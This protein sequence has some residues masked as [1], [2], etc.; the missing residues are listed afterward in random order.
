MVLNKTSVLLADDHQIVLDGLQ[1][2]LEPEFSIV[3]AVGDGRALIQAAQR[4]KPDVIVVDISMPLLNGID[5]TRKIRQRDPDARIIVLTM[6]PDLP[7]ATEAFE[8][9]AMGYVIKTSAGDELV[10]AIEAVMLGHNYVT[11]S[12]AKDL[13]DAVIHGRAESGDTGTPLTTRQRE[14]MQL[15]AEGHSI[16]E[17]AEILSVSPKT[18]EYH[19]YRMMEILD[20]ASTSELKQYAIKHRIVDQS[21]S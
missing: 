20:L 18:V 14:V 19:K 5:A 13:V 16:K 21:T 6:H 15:V 11:P 4:L 3:G 10:T 12:I 9:G 1:R 8:A 17:M 7:Y 2:I